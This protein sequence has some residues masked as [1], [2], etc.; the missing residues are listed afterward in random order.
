M[1]LDLSADEMRYSVFRS[2][3]ATVFLGL[4]DACCHNHFQFRLPPLPLLLLPTTSLSLPLSIGVVV[5]SA[6]CPRT[7]TVWKSLP[8]DRISD[9]EI[10]VHL[11]WT[12]NYI[13]S[14]LF[15][16]TLHLL[17][18]LAY[19]LPYFLYVYSC[20]MNS[21]VGWRLIID[22]AY[23]TKWLRIRGRDLCLDLE[24]WDLNVLLLFFFGY[25][26]YYS[27][28]TC[29]YGLP[30]WCGVWICLRTIRM[31]D[32]GGGPGLWDLQ[33]GGD[34][35]LAARSEEVKVGIVLLASLRP[36]ARP[37]ARMAVWAFLWTG[38]TKNEWMDEK[39]EWKLYINFFFS[40]F[41]SW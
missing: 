32:I 34:L 33:P 19:W 16:S 8:R 35:A 12:M 29:I 36:F 20:I 17:I 37:L 1:E 11:G 14:S 27:L 28:L 25:G 7:G 6:F 41:D 22:N 31:Y 9:P 23:D 2:A 40:W 4:C 10:V 26:G 38:E 5:K 30:P 24:M 39:G 15:L 21:H 18:N 3:E 13:T